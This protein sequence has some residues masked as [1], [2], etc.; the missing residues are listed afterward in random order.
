MGPRM[1]TP[2]P[3]LL[4]KLPI[5]LHHHAYT[6]GDHEQTRQ[7][8]EDVLGLPLVAMYIEREYIDGEWVELG[9]AFYGLGDGSALA[10]FNFA[11]PQ[12]QAAWQ[13]KDQSRFIHVSLLVDKT[14]Q[15]E[16]KARLA[17]ADIVPFTVEHGYCTSLYV[18]DPNGL[19]V[20][21]TVDDEQ[22]PDIAM[23]M[24]LVA[25]HEMRRWIAGDRTPNN[26]WRG[27]TAP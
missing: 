7:F 26:R 4:K 19:L 16:I 24:A 3:L 9:H 23:E 15:R 11:D 25:H 17:A 22:A 10:F 5:R 8:Y 14:T 1:T 13:A 27:V 18:K 12:K 2:T 20:E 21:F 6:T